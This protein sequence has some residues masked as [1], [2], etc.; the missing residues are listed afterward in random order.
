VGFLLWKPNVL[1]FFAGPICDRVALHCLYRQLLPLRLWD[2]WD[3]NLSLFPLC[4]KLMLWG[5]FPQNQMFYICFQSTQLVFFHDAVEHIVRAARVFR[6]PG[7]HLLLVSMKVFL[8]VFLCIWQS[9]LIIMIIIK[10]FYTVRYF[11]KVDSRRLNN[12]FFVFNSFTASCEN[13]MSLA[14]PGVPAP[15]EKFPHSSQINF[16]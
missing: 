9:N 15:C 3:T 5:F 1:K 12:F 16:E 2:P 10:H 6:Q 8:C 14:V 11:H 7:G 4:H 13:A